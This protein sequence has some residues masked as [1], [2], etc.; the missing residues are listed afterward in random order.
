MS[1]GKRRAGDLDAYS[2]AAATATGVT[3]TYIDSAH[4]FIPQSMCVR[5]L[6]NVIRV[7]LSYVLKRKR[8]TEVVT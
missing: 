2:A 8:K 1:A 3:Y 7:H 4:A 6:E 5:L